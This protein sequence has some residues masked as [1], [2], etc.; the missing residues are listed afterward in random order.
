VLTLFQKGD[1][2]FDLAAYVSRGLA[3][4]LKGIAIF[5]SIDVSGDAQIADYYEISSFPAVIFLSPAGK[6]L[7]KHEGYLSKEDILST[8][9]SLN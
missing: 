2:E 9:K 7:S 8:L 6:V 3:W 5:Q 1:G 4:E